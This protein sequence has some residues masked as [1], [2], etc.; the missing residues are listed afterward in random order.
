MGLSSKR[1]QIFTWLDNLRTF[2]LSCIPSKGC[3][4]SHSE[5]GFELREGSAFILIIIS[6][7]NINIAQNDKHKAN[8][9]NI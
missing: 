2:S 7:L 4:A 8:S 1:N 3:R 6:Y 9:M 5:L